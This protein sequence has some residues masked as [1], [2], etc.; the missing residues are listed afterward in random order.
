MKLTRAE[1]ALL[2]R[3]AANGGKSR[4]AKLSPARRSAIAANAANARWAREKAKRT[5]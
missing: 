4:A 2:T 1:R 3:I 5:A